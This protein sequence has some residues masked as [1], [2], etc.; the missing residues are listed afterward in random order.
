[1]S[2]I[3]G[4]VVLD[5]N[6]KI[7]SSFVENIKEIYMETFSKCAI[8]CFCDVITEKT[9]MSCGLQYFTKEAEYEKLP[10]SFLNYVYNADV[11][12]DNREE[13]IRKISAD[14]NVSDKIL[15]DCDDNIADGKLLDLIYQNY[16]EHVLDEIA[17][18]Y[19]AVWYDIKKNEVIIL[20]DAVGYRFVYYTIKDNILY[21]SSLMKP[22]E[23]IIAS[24]KLNERYLADFIGQDN[25]NMFTECEETPIKDIYRTAPASYIKISKNR[26]LKK[27]YWRP[28]EN[29]KQIKY[30]TNEEYKQH[31]LNLFNKCVS[32]SLRSGG[33]TGVLL[34]GG[35][36]SSAVAAVAA[37][38]LEKKG[39]K[40]YSFTSVPLSE[41]AKECSEQMKFYETDETEMVKKT[42]Q[43]IRNIVPVFMDMPQMNPWDDR[44]K[45]MQICEIPYKSPQNLLWMYEGYKQCQMAGG[46]I[47]LGGMFGNSTISYENATLYF[48]WLV[49]H[50]KF[51]KLY[52]EA[53]ALKKRHN[54]SRKI[55]IKTAFK[56]AFS[57]N[58]R[59]LDNFKNDNSFAK[60]EYINENKTNERIEKNMRTIK[61]ALLSCENYQKV[62]MSADVFRHYGEFAQKNSLYSGVILKDPTRDKR[63]IEFALSVPYG[64][65]THDGYQ[66]ALVSDYMK[67][68][69]PKHILEA[70]KQGR[71]SA[72]LKNRIV[73]EKRR[74]KEEWIDI[75]LNHLN[76]NRI[77]SEDAIIQLQ[78]K[79]I[80]KMTDFEIVRHIY[81]CIFLEYTDEKSNK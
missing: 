25:Y 59:F 17:G 68:I 52:K 1:M 26:I 19:C 60:E 71:Q 56:D 49:K 34:S 66:R 23:K 7:D 72:D 15:S 24:V 18:A 35:Y 55:I 4:A 48:A 46:K 67:D 70:K 32:D 40:L 69:V 57:K 76:D 44:K 65:Y 30:K 37:A 16:G 63:I 21:Y 36:D 12:L 29:I 47:L 43:C 74:I 73:K 42:V 38:L 6:R 62:M 39:Q 41:F 78:H 50:A 11:I 20:S 13:L 64:Q 75:Y 77:N 79:D 14:K 58:D 81:T 31:F 2:A 9:Y 28:F 51:I 53:D 27:I 10:A 80:E 5:K 45:Y 54:Y 8:D 33:N 22:L 61:D 3:F